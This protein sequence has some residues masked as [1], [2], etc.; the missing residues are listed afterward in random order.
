MDVVLRM[1][2][3]QLE[4]L[5][6]LLLFVA[7]RSSERATQ[8]YAVEARRLGAWFICQARLQGWR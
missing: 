3:E 7:E 1:T 4:A 5:L 2:E 6:E 8:D